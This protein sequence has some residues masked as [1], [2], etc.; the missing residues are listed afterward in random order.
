MSR[1][2]PPSP[3][4]AD[5]EDGGVAALFTQLMPIGDP[6]AVDLLIELE[7]ALYQHVRNGHC[8]VTVSTKL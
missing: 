4:R 1:D 2:N 7:K 3:S 8:L 6:V 5:R